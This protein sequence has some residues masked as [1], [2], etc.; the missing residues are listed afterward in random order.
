MSPPQP[1]PNS[2]DGTATNRVVVWRSTF[3]ATRFLSILIICMVSSPNSVTVPTTRELLLSYSGGIPGSY[4]QQQIELVC[5]GRTAESIPD[6]TA[7][8]TTL[9][10]RYRAERDRYT[11]PA[12]G[13]FLSEAR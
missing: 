12:V 9:S 4:R 2:T 7:V 5:S 10:H 8:W 1:Q 3:S 13:P 6:T 11:G